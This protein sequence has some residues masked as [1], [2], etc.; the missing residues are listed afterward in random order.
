VAFGSFAG[1]MTKAGNNDRKATAR[2]L[3][4]VGVVLVVI[5]LL[6]GFAQPI[7]KRI[8]TASFTLYSAGWC[9]LLL[10]LFYWWIDVKGHT[11]GWGWLLCYGCNA[12]T[13]YLIG[14]LINFRGIAESLIYGTA[15]YL[16]GWYPVL[17]TACN[18]LIIFFI[19]W[20][21]Y[22]NKLFLKV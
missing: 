5:G 14:E 17:L 8:W 13:A 16:E 2:R 20:F 19:L 3:A 10:A 15:Q 18:S 1:H 6:C 11:K 22:K 4:V 7:I 9:Y 12:I 21:M